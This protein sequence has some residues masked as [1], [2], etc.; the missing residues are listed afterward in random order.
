M[1]TQIVRLQGQVEHIQER[2]KSFVTQAE[3]IPVRIIAYG[4]TGMTLTSVFAA[5]LAKVIIK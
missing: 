2:M 3:F 5:L 4:L 1:G